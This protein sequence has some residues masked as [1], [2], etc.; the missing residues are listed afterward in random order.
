MIGDDDSALRFQQ[1]L[2]QVTHRSHRE[3]VVLKRWYVRVVVTDQRPLLLQKLDDVQGEGFP[4]IA[5]A[6]L[7]TTS[8]TS[9]CPPAQ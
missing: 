8:S 1:S 3:T 4:Q 7:N 2:V 5:D 9:T 6:F